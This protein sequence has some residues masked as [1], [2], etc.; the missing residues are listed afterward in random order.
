M[1]GF[2]G[3]LVCSTKLVCLWRALYK[4]LAFYEICLFAVHY[5]SVI[6]YST[7]PGHAGSKNREER[8][9]ENA[10]WTL[11]FS[12]SQKPRDTTTLSMMAFSIMT[13]S[14]MTLSI[15]G[16]FV[17]FKIN[18][19]QHNNTASML[20][21]IYAECHFDVCSYAECCRTKQRNVL[22]Y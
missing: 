4:T 21:V 20:N 13:F 22:A 18:N 6:F 17:T 5:G 1:Y 2:C 3:K 15:K 11:I 16:L 9:M 10:R 7:V 14:V 19:I 8:M 12:D